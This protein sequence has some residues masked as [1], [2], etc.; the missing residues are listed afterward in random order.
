MRKAVDAPNYRHCRD[1]GRKENA[2]ITHNREEQS[3]GNDVLRL[4]AVTKE[5]ADDLPCAVGDGKTRDNNGKRR[6]FHLHLM[7]NLNQ[8]NGKIDTHTIA[9]KVNCR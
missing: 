3:C 2:H 5:S 8:H 7:A 4:K 1:S 9:C 6:F